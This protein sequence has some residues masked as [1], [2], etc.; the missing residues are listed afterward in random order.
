MSRL[1]IVDDHGAV[2]QA[3]RRYFERDFEQVVVTASPAEAETVITGPTP[4]THLICDYWLGQGTP[5][6][7]ALVPRWR[8]LF[9]S[10][11]RAVLLTGSDLTEHPPVPGVDAICD[12]PIDPAQLRRLLLG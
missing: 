2:A 5:V 6:G 10:L 3:L 4:P 7:T 8:R 9:P 12:K 11:E 1:L